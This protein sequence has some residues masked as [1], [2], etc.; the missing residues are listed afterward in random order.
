[1]LNFRRLVFLLVGT[2]LVL[3]SNLLAQCGVERWSVKTGTHAA[4]GLVNLNAP[5]NTTIATMRAFPAPNPIPA[6]NRVSPAETT[7]WVINATLTVFK[8]ESDSDYHLVIQDASGD[9]M[10]TEIP[11]PSCVGSTSPF[12]SSIQHASGK[13]NAQLT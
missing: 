2:L 12:L 1:M 7:L 3:P 4:A 5:M 9:T 8:L 6:N 10:I 11:A 13:F